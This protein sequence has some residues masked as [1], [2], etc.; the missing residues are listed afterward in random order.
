MDIQLIEPEQHDAPKGARTPEVPRGRYLGDGHD[1]R[2]SDLLPVDADFALEV[3]RRLD[4]IY[5]R[6]RV[7]PRRP[8][9]SAVFPLAQQLHEDDFM[10]AAITWGDATAQAEPTNTRLLAVL[11]DLRGGGF[12]AALCEA[13]ILQLARG[14]E[15]SHRELQS[16][17]YLARDHAKIMRNAIVDLDPDARAAD[18]AEN[19]HDLRSFVTRWDGARHVLG[20]HRVA[21]SARA[22][23]NTGLASCCLETS[24]IDRVL[25]NLVNNATRFAADSKVE[26]EFLHVTPRVVRILISNSLSGDQAE[27][28]EETLSKDPHA[29]H[30]AGVTRGGAGFGLANAAHF[31]SSA[32]G[33]DPTTAVEYG[34][35]GSEVRGRRYTAWVHWP[36][37]E[38][39]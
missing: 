11:H 28:L 13:Q 30:R 21:V 31:V 35:L 27:W 25:Y 4:R 20:E 8:D 6:W 3:Y 38:G 10:V 5:Q 18:L 37:F 12:T 34:Y 23:Q 36:V 24:A 14:S 29:L 7:S 9:W 16:I 1:I 2:L 15:D 33:V 32:F 22:D 17:V 39:E 19:P 26:I